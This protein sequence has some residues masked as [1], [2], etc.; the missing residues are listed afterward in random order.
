MIEKDIENWILNYLSIPSETFNNIPLC[1]FAKQAWLS[2][3]V[4]VLDTLPQNIKELLQNY[5]VIIYA[6]N[7]N[8]ITAEDLFN[9]AVSLSDDVIVALDDHPNH[10]EKVGDVVLNNGKYALLLIQERK[11]LEHARQILKS[12]G[13]YNNWDP[14]YLEEVLGA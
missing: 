8:D 3:K 2:K 14:E 1:P 11:K 7:P 9:L 6:L 4:L 13:Y 10:Q 12:K 5:E